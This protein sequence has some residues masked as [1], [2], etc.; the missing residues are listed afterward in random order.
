MAWYLGPN[1]SPGQAYVPD[2]VAQQLVKESGLRKMDTIPK[3]VIVRYLESMGLS[4]GLAPDVAMVLRNNYGITPTFDESVQFTSASL[5][6]E[7]GESFAM[8]FRDEGPKV[9]TEAQLVESLAGQMFG[10]ASSTSASVCAL[11]EG[12]G[13]SQLVEMNEFCDLVGPDGLE[14]IEDMAQCG[15]EGF[16]EEVIGVFV[17]DVTGV[18]SFVTEDV[19][20]WADGLWEVSQGKKRAEQ[21]KAARSRTQSRAEK[22]KAVR[23]GPVP[24]KAGAGRG[25]VATS[26]P[27]I[28]GPANA[29]SSERAKL[30]KDISKK[31]PFQSAKGQASPRETG[32][33]AAERPAPLRKSELSKEIARK[34]PF[35]TDK[36]MTARQAGAE[37]RKARKGWSDTGPGPETRP[38]KERLAAKAAELKRQKEAPEREAKAKAASEKNRAA[39]KEKFAQQKSDKAQSRDYAAAEKKL[40]KAKGK[41]A[42]AS[43]AGKEDPL[44]KKQFAQDTDSRGRKVR[45][46]KPY[47]KPSEADPRDSLSDKEIQSRTKKSRS[48]SK[49]IE[50]TQQAAAKQR[51]KDAA[52]ADKAS[53]PSLLKRAGEKISSIFK[54]KEA[55]APDRPL[56]SV[57]AAEKRI[58]Q[59][60]GQTTTG[61]ATPGGPAGQTTTGSATPS[62]PGSQPSASDSSGGSDSSS[63][64][65]PRQRSNTS[66]RNPSGQNY[67]KRDLT[68]QSLATKLGYY[69]SRGVGR[70]RKGYQA[71]KPSNDSPS[72]PQPAPSA[73]GSSS[74]PGARRRPNVSTPSTESVFMRHASL[75]EELTEAVHGSESIPEQEAWIPEPSD[76]VASFESTT[77]IDQAILEAISTLGWDAVCEAARFIAISPEYA[78]EL[79]QAHQQ[80]VRSFRDTWHQLESD[81]RLPREMK[82]SH[83]IRLAERVGDPAIM[84]GFVYWS[85][86]TLSEAGDVVAQVVSESY[87]ELGKTIYAPAGDPREGPNFAKEYMSPYPP[88][89]DAPSR[90]MELMT[91]RLFQDVDKRN[92]ERKASL[93]VVNTVI[94]NMQASAAS[95]GS[96]P[97]GMFLNTYRDMHR[98]RVRYSSDAD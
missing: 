9:L 44:A 71:G 96:Y 62:S 1:V 7:L 60:V 26:D 57:S 82:M 46:A 59:P 52:T 92:A 68:G 37:A 2:Q 30:L 34:D 35:Q 85:A 11:F 63:T 95:S 32:K 38:A 80:G 73:Q 8:P 67:T 13:V 70:F 36:R 49:N 65:S 81:D 79:F 83:F 54:K 16:A 27:K 22:R 20:V 72:P 19:G 14:Y 29:S 98:E 93:G 4:A 86:R 69:A 15:P 90:G 25:K 88:S 5:L 66:V 6:E 23:T 53:R 74:A 40:R 51:E 21:R 87:P 64:S 10:E 55:P 12:I 28:T 18:D 45:G 33:Q 77:I 31:D 24:S 61:S 43:I 75:I 76:V 97:E 47:P 89:T 17:N 50:K 41:Q 58:K 56:S 3:R 48:I 94:S 91:P 84:P 78:S 42:A 39:Q